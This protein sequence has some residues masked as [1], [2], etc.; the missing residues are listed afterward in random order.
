MSDNEKKE[1]ENLQP[2]QDTYRTLS[3]SNRKMTRQMILISL[4]IFG[5]LLLLA[6][7]ILLAGKWISDDSGTNPSE[8]SIRFYP[9]YEGDI[10]ADREYLELDRSISY[11]ADPDGYGETISMTD[12]NIEE[13]NAEIRFL[14]EWILLMTQGDSG[15]YNACFTEN[16]FRSHEKQKSFAPQMI[17]QTVIYYQSVSSDE[18]T[19][20]RLVTYRLSYR[21]HRNDGT[22]RNDVGSDGAKPQYVVLRI[23]ADGSIGIDNL[24]TK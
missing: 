14:R 1:N 2:A 16:Y 15:R 18:N 7:G 22:V 9:P 19:G 21:I 24:Y 13:F 6:T 10:F 4:A 8:G 12:E 23:S 20:E 17:W 11:C 5:G 3:G